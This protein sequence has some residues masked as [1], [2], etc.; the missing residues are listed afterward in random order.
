MWN[1]NSIDVHEETGDVMIGGGEGM[2]V[3]PPPYSVA[4]SIWENLPEPVDEILP[5]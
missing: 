3:Y 4:N 2:W 5:T 1:M